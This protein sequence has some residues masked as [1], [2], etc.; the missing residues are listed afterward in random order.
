MSDT[1]ELARDL[2]RRPSITPED[3]GC[4][5]LMMQRLGAQGF[6]TEP[7]PFGDVENLWARRGSAG[8]VFCFAGHT[9]VVPPGPRDLWHSD[10]FQPVIRDGILYG[11]GAAD[12]KGSLA[13]MVTASERFVARYP[14]HKGSITFLITSDEEGPAV[15]GTVKVIEKLKA[16]SEAI[17]W[18]LVGEPSSTSRVGDVV[19]NGRRGSLGGVLVVRGVQ[20]H[21]AYPN[22]ASNPVHA[23]VPALSELT[24]TEWDQ[25][26]NFFP[27][28]TFQISNIHAGTGATN[29]IPGT[30]EVVFNFRYSTESDAESLR[31]RVE[32]LLDRHDLD[33]A[34]KWNLS[35]LP[36]LTP[37]GALIEAAQAAIQTVAGFRTQLSTAGGTS[38]GRFIAPTGAQVLELGPCNATIHQ[39]NECVAVKDLDTLSAMYEQILIRLLT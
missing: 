27:K 16:R 38:D 7:L 8:P 11:R 3:A 5:A 1:L 21:V 18:C 15:D 10:P 14:N 13:A 25:G 29:V 9:D 36:F 23:T 32:A 2:I 39:V 24:A 4:Q 26:N 28:T 19:K 31:T 37:G 20:G 22:L 33:Y 34:I 12:M 17:E 30:C 35:G 6:S